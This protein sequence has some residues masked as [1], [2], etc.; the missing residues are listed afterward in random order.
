MYGYSSNLYIF[1]CFSNGSL[2]ATERSNSTIQVVQVVHCYTHAGIVRYCCRK[3]VMKARN[4]RT[5]KARNTR[6]EKA[7]NRR[8]E[9]ARNRRTEK[10][11]NRRTEKSRNRRTE[12]ARNRRTEKARTVQLYIP[13]LIVQCYIPGHGQLNA[14]C[15]HGMTRW[16]V[17]N[18]S[19]LL[20]QQERYDKTQT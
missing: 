15:T 7:R 14:T 4:R 12:K 18:M 10:A 20:E 13:W 8:T 6:T 1:E 17:V 9:K 3:Y 11:R 16:H 2:T 5:E 19:H